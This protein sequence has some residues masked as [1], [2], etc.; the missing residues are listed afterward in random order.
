MC[1]EM[2]QEGKALRE[3]IGELRNKY[4]TSETWAS[5]LAGR[6]ADAETELYEVRLSVVWKITTKLK[7]LKNSIR[8]AL[9]S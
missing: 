9:F 6:V 3:M 8:V 4:Q 1:Q 2:R 7:A 5:A